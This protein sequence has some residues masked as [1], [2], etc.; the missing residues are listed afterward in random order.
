[1][2]KKFNFIYSN[3]FK[4]LKILIIILLI[5]FN[6]K[7]FCILPINFFCLNFE[8]IIEADKYENFDEIKKN[9]SDPFLLNILK[10]IHIIK[11]F[12][13]KKMEIHK[14]RKLIMH[15]TLS[16]NNDINYKYIILVSM[17]SLLIN[18]KKSK[19]FIIFHILCSPDF[20]ESSTIIFKS[21]MA[22]FYRNLQIIF[23]NM[24]HNF[25]NR[26][27]LRY[28][29]AAYY[30]LITA[31]FI[32]SDRIMHLDCDTLIFSDLAEV[33]NLDFND[34]YVLGIYDYISRGI[35]YLGIKSNIYINSGVILLNLKKIR[36]DR[37]IVN[38]LNMTQSNIKLYNVDQTVINFIFYPKI[39]RIPSKYVIFNFEDID[40]INIYLKYLRTKIS[41]KEIE[42]SLKNPVIIH[43]IICYPKVWFINS[44]YRKRVTN[45]IK[46]NNC[47]CKRYYDKWHYFAK[48][49]DYYKEILKF[50]SIKFNY[51]D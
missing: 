13:P 9:T 29:E 48:K 40:D 25:D 35:D 49:T 30:R 36:E 17:Y 20:N 4:N 31:V 42:E 34:N 15:I 33:Y 3:L 24:G 5:N 8:K 45:C 27:N 23:Y 18:C 11:H 32:H 22:K 47:S 19:T 12:Y 26:K 39:G 51:S 28:S 46:R 10:E 7:L 50:T 43:N 16:V 14:K 1:M 38:I 37:K 21:L 2:L 6:I 44:V 41:I